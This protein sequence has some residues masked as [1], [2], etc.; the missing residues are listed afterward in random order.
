[1]D[2]GVDEIKDTAILEKQ[3]DICGESL[4]QALRIEYLGPEQG[5]MFLVHG[6]PYCEHCPG[7]G[8]SLSEYAEPEDLIKFFLGKFSEVLD[9]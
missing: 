2:S 5:F 6:E 1:M 8:R 3:C 7:P 9:G 4:F